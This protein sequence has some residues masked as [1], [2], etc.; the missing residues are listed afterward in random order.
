MSV[1]FPLEPWNAREG[2]EWNALTDLDCDVEF[3]GQTRHFWLR[4]VGN[5]LCFVE[6]ANE[7][8][9]PI[10]ALTH[11]LAPT[12]ERAQLFRQAPDVVRAIFVREFAARR[13]GTYHGDK[14]GWNMPCLCAIFCPEGRVYTRPWYDDRPWLVFDYDPQKWDTPRAILD[15]QM[16]QPDK[17]N[18]QSEASQA[19]MRENFMGYLHHFE[20]PAETLAPEIGKRDPLLRQRA[21]FEESFRWEWGDAEQTRRLTRAVWQFA[22][23]VWEENPDAN[24][25]RVETSS[26]TPLYPYKL[27]C[28]LFPD[29]PYPRR[30]S[31]HGPFLIIWHGLITRFNSSRGA[32]WQREWEEDADPPHRRWHLVSYGDHWDVPRPTMHDRLE[33]GL[34]LREWMQDKVDSADISRLLERSDDPAA[35][36]EDS[37]YSD[38]YRDYL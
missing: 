16:P 14:G 20:L 34:F 23:H 9:M 10:F 5:L 33:S 18:P 37:F 12:H 24:S 27:D 19:N 11:L 25:V 4:Q 26:E 2:A 7:R 22:T 17:E 8:Q 6:K 38:F 15:W 28:T 1:F 21:I 32:T 3:E 36:K 29:Q 30:K 31:L 13:W 35:W